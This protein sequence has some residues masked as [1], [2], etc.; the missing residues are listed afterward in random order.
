MD[1]LTFL[2]ALQ[3]NDT[4]F[5]TGAF[6][7]SD[8]LETA[9]SGGRVCDAADLD[10]WMAHVVEVVLAG[11]DGPA[12][13]G[14][15]AAY[16]Q[17]DWE[18]VARLDREVTAL[19]PAASARAG[20]S[21]VGRRLIA[22]WRALQ[23]SARFEAFASVV[24]GRRL[25]ANLPIAYGAVAVSAGLDA[26]AMLLG[27]GY[28]RLAGVASAALRLM[29]IGQQAAQ[30]LLTGRLASLPTVV[31]AVLARGVQAPRTFAPAQDIEQMAHR[32]V[33]S[34]LFRS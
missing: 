20:S 30:R 7:Y 6:A 22:T 4:L 26:R 25:P 16:A 3:L 1:P 9:V 11:C 24:E 13:L 14:A 33:Y 17:G 15:A 10:G 27:Y 12:A 34:R 19:K 8:G 31:D 28:G 18:A 29:P 5:P 32:R 21:L 2:H 23:A